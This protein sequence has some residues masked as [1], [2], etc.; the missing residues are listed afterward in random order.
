MFGPL[1]D[2]NAFGNILN[3]YERIMRTK[4]KKTLKDQFRL[5]YIWR[6]LREYFYLKKADFV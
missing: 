3:V 6:H 2:K 4:K 1:H 5:S